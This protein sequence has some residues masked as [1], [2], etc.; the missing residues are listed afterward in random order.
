MNYQQALIYI[1]QISSFRSTTTLGL[2]RIQQLLE[3]IGNPQKQ[4]KCIHVAGTN[5]KGSACAMLQSILTQSGYKTALYTSPHLIKYNERYQIDGAYISD[6]K[7]AQEVCFIKKH[8]TQMIDEGF[9]APTLFEFLTAICFHYFAQQNVDIVLLET[10]LGGL[11]DATNII[12]NPLLC[13]IMSIGIDHIEFLGN[14]IEQIAIE[15]AGII[16]QNCAVVLYPQK[17][18]VYNKIADICKQKQSPL[19]DLQNN[20]KTKILLQ[21]LEKTLFSVSTKYFQYDMVNLSLL[22]E[23]QIQNCITVLLACHVLKQYGFHLTEQTILNSIQKTKWQGRMEIIQHYPIVILDGAHNIDGIIMLS[24]SIKKYFKHK[25]ITLLIGVLQE[26]E[27]QKMIDI[28]LPM[29]DIVVLTEPMSSRKLDIEKLEKTMQYSHKKILKNAH[30]IEAY[31]TALS[32][33]AKKD[34][35][36]CCG[37]LYMIGEIKSAQM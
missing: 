31:Q 20:V 24:H 17:N 29:V 25:K 4:L 22:G 34:I 19:Y 27:Y 14:T 16:K 32:I 7:F 36:L 26:K 15:K 30:V 37:S 10:G 11:S 8:Y 9:E 35:L 1:N 5:G 21:N 13:L 28:I 12:E 23:Y 6:E 18:L 2:S 3:R 33:T